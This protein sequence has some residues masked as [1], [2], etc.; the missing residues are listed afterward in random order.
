MTEIFTAFCRSLDNYYSSACL[1]SFAVLK[2][3]S[4]FQV[5]AYP[6]RMSS[7]GVV[8]GLIYCPRA[9][10]GRT[11]THALFGLFG[12]YSLQKFRQPKQ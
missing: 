5:H 10:K 3:I 1:A 8:H 2:Q 9:I 12:K 6:M 4:A 7:L 11:P